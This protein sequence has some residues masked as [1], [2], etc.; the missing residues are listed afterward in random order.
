MEDTILRLVNSTSG[1]VAQKLLL[2]VMAE[3]GNVAVDIDEFNAI[4]EELVKKGRVIRVQYVIPP[5]RAHCNKMRTGALYL[6]ERSVVIVNQ[7]E[8]VPYKNRR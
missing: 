2:D 4:V 7:A 5:D 6:P 8:Y 1:V 3:Y